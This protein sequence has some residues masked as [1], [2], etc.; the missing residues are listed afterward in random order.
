[1]AKRIVQLFCV[2]ILKF[3]PQETWH[4]HEAQQLAS[5]DCISTQL[6]NLESP[7]ATP[8]FN[9]WSLLDRVKMLTQTVKNR[10]LSLKS[11]SKYI[12]VLKKMWN[13]KQSSS[14]SFNCIAIFKIPKPMKTKYRHSLFHPNSVRPIY[15]IPKGLI[16]ECRFHFLLKNKNT[17]NNNHPSPQK[18]TQKNKLHINPHKNPK[19]QSHITF[20][21]TNLNFM[22]PCS[23][24]LA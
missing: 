12:V 1:M 13:S 7:S 3:L 18:S 16:L 10:G 6:A 9:S 8:L 4:K 20:L 22:Y 11:I 14:Y 21:S 17:T 2:S 19:S 5:G 23:F 24:G 15:G